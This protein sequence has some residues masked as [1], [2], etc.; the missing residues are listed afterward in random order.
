VGPSP[1]A[2]AGVAPKI[3]AIKAAAVN[4]SNEGVFMIFLLLLENL[5]AIVVTYKKTYGIL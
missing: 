5:T 4:I 2:N 1:A 3:N